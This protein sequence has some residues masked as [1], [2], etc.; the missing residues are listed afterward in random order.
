MSLVDRSSQELE[1]LD[2]QIENTET[3]EKEKM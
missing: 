2:E 3:P 1:I